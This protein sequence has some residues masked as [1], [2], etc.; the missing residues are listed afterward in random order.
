MFQVLIYIILIEVLIVGSL[1]DNFLF[2]RKIYNN[3]APDFIV[4]KEK[5]I[6]AKLEVEGIIKK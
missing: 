5:I 6:K 1:K 4:T 2:F 3:M